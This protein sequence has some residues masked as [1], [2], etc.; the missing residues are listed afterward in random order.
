MDLSEK[1][2]KHSD[3]KNKDLQQTFK[4]LRDL[5]NDIAHGKSTSLSL[6]KTMDFIRFLRHLSKKIDKH[7]VEHFFILE[8]ADYNI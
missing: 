7:L 5:R 4:I 1:V 2:N 8:N 6:D 3:L